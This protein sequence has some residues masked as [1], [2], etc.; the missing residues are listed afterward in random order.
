M[1]YQNLPILNYQLLRAYLEE[2]E[3][4]EKMISF[5]FKDC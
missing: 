2:S 1:K 5:K 3:L 4:V